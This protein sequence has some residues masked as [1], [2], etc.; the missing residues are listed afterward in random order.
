MLFDDER[1]GE[2]SQLLNHVRLLPP[3]RD[4]AEKG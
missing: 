3:A 1:V 4:T 2:W